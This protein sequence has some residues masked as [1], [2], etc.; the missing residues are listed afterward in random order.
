MY[1]VSSVRSDQMCA[2]SVVEL[3]QCENKESKKML[4]S[5]LFSRQAIGIQRECD[6]EGHYLSRR[7]SK[8]ECP[9]AEGCDAAVEVG[10]AGLKDTVPERPYHSYL[11]RI[12]I[13]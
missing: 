4:K 12:R 8:V 1:E 5:V 10:L 2:S 6:G 11:I 7:T 9:S 3:D 13:P